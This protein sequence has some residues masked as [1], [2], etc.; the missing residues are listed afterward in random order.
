M[1][2]LHYHPVSVWVL[3]RFY[4]LLLQSINMPVILIWNSEFTIDNY[5]SVNGCL[6]LCVCGSINWQLLQVVTLLKSR[7]ARIDASRPLKP[8]CSSAVYLSPPTLL[9]KIKGHLN[10]IIATLVE[11]KDSVVQMAKT[12]SKNIGNKRVVPKLVTQHTSQFL[13]FR[14]DVLVTF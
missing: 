13:C 1:C 2:S 14:A 9:R 12:I 7:T 10:N 3:S 11:N 5:A 8:W 6:S 4:G